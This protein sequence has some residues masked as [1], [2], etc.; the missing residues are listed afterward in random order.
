MAGNRPHQCRQLNWLSSI[1]L[2]PLAVS[3]KWPDLGNSRE[4]FS[5]QMVCW[6]CSMSMVRCQRPVQ[7]HNHS[8][9]SV[10]R[11]PMIWMDEVKT[12]FF[13]YFLSILDIISLNILR[14]FRF[15]TMKMLNNDI[16]RNMV[17]IGC[18][19]NWSA[20]RDNCW[21]VERIECFNSNTIFREN[22]YR[23]NCLSAESNRP[24]QFVCEP[25][26]D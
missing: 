14:R 3:H 24:T 19:Y 15:L 25:K 5:Y 6:V 22:I 10:Y 13:I 23:E 21:I 9:C 4:S 1:L 12:A 11:P 2:W 20:P 18:A 8:N 26:S 7:S 16:K 17:T